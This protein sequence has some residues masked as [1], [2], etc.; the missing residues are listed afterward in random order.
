MPAGVYKISPFGTSPVRVYCDLETMDGG[1]T[2]IQKRVGGFVNFDRNWSEYKNGFGA[3]EHNYWVGNDVIHLLT[4]EKNSSLYISITVQNGTRLHELYNG[5]SVSNE[6]EK[7]Q[8]FLA[9]PATGTLGGSI[10]ADYLRRMYFSTPDR[11]NDRSSGGNSAASNGRK[12]G[13]WFD[14]CNIAFLNGQ[15]ASADW[16]W[17]WFTTVLKG[18][19]V[20][21]TVMMVKRH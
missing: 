6:T 13:W 21:E 19:S 5:F 14:K 20:R 16:I 9:G 8:L 7:Y 1:W 11:D 15:W 12:G 17:P 4:N 18:T 3:A 2:A 10:E